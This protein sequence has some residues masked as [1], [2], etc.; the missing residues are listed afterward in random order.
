MED[1][2]EQC[3]SYAEKKVRALLHHRSQFES[4]MGISALDNAM[5]TDSFR[6]R[7]LLGLDRTDVDNGLPVAEGFKRISD[8]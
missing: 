7:I 6:K 3:E 5:E 2:F 8:L 1:H 4:T